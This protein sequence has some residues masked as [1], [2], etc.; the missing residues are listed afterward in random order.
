MNCHVNNTKYA[1]F[2]L[3]AFGEVLSSDDQIVGFRI[4]YQKEILDGEIIRIH[5]STT[6]NEDG[7]RTIACRGET[8]D[9]PVKFGASFKIK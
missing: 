7:T 2:A 1:N 8:D 9:V 4:D 5:F 3:S 6:E